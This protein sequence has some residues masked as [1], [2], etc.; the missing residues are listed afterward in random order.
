MLTQ[1]HRMVTKVLAAGKA[2]CCHVFTANVV[3]I[4]NSRVKDFYRK[5]HNGVRSSM[6]SLRLKHQPCHMPASSTCRSMAYGASTMAMMHKA[7]CPSRV[8]GSTW[9]HRMCQAPQELDSTHCDTVK[10]TIDLPAAP[11]PGHLGQ[12]V[13]QTSVCNVCDHPRR[14]TE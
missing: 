2:L 3:V 11:L 1:I 14:S 6:Q 9:C 7:S 10:T 13:C 8:H 5:P 12:V 4:S